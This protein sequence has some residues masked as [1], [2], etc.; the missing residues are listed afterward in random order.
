MRQKPN[1]IFIRMMTSSLLWRS[2]FHGVYRGGAVLEIQ[3]NEDDAS[4]LDA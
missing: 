1:K 4:N 2:G 3:Y